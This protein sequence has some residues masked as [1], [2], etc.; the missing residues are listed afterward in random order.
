YMALALDNI[1]HDPVAFARASAYRGLRLFMIQGTSDRLTAQQF[2]QSRRVYAAANAISIA[3]LA[4]FAIGVMIAWRRGGHGFVL[5]LVVI[6][7]PPLT[8]APVLTNMRYSV[9]V[10]PLMFMF[11][12]V[13]LVALAAW[14]ER[15]R[16]DHATHSSGG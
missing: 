9:P 5:P 13:A 4:L 15:L 3:Y 8:L 11:T 1:R 12:A 2:D 16:G 14:F 6:A 10:Q 7:Y